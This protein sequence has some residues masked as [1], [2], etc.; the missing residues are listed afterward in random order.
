MSKKDWELA[1]LRD[2]QIRAHS[3]RLQDSKQSGQEKESET[4]KIEELG[5]SEEQLKAITDS[6][7]KE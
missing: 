5:L 4:R 1:A 3:K 6:L 7:N 2:A